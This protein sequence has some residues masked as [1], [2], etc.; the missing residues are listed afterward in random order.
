MC[1]NARVNAQIVHRHHFLKTLHAPLT[2]GFAAAAD[3]SS[4]IGQEY[5]AGIMQATADYG[6][7][8]INMASAVH[9]SVL[10]D[11][12]FLPQFITKTQFMRAPLLDGLVTWASSLCD[13]MESAKIQ[14]LFA[15]LAPLPM[16]DIGFLDI[17]GVPSIR[18]DN[19]HA[20]RL[21][22]AHLVQ[23]HGFSR[24]VFFGAKTSHPHELRK[25]YFIEEMRARSLPYTDNA[26]FM[27]DALDGPAVEKQVAALLATYGNPHQAGERTFPEAIVTSSDII[28]A[29]VLDA[30]EKQGIA[31]PDDVTVTGFNNQLVG[32]TSG[33]PITT[34]DL[35]YFARGYRA[36]E[37]LIDRI[38]H[39]DKPCPSQLVETSLIVRQS[40]GCFEHAVTEA[41]HATTP[42]HTVPDARASMQDIRQ[43]L[44]RALTDLFPREEKA[45]APAM[46]DAILYDLYDTNVSP[47]RHFLLA[48]ARCLKKGA[49]RHSARLTGMTVFL[50]CA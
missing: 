30:L 4:Y 39:P 1:Y 8:F 9:H 12:H 36:V 34:I 42:S 20:M 21:I 45:I 37:L 19:A 49:R 15:S 25:R 7:N 31:V 32:I 16:V 18:I 44:E 29:H 22:I 50:P 27:A 47:I 35:S 17:A 11:V 13:Y 46:T 23:A 2:F 5:L 41:L 43:Y 14:A 6:I 40:C 38:M 10:E 28:A 48:F 26:I 3:F 24:M 33:T